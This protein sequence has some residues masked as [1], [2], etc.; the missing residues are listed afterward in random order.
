MARTTNGGNSFVNFKISLLPF[1]PSESIFFGDYNNLSVER[2]IIR[3]I[4]TRMESGNLSVWTA[5][6]DTM[7]IPGVVTA[8][9]SPDPFVEMLT[10]YPNPFNN[11]SFVSFKLKKPGRVSLS[12]FDA[13]GKKIAEPI[14]EK[15]YVTGKYIEA[16]QTKQ[17]ELSPGLYFYVITINDKLYT[18]KLLYL[19]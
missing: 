4:W 1:V 11:N 8:V 17:L 15:W 18:R 19:D 9:N 3:P 13:A 5:L 14:H 10:A 12:I 2:G 16:I 7:A 6:I